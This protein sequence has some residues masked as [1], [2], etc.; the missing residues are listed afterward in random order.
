MT[1]R[2]DPVVRCNSTAGVEGAKKKA[3][4]RACSVIHVASEAHE[5]NQ[6]VAAPTGAPVSEA[7][8]ARIREERQAAGHTVRGL[9]ARIDVSPSLISQ[10]ERGRATPSVGTLWAIATEL[11]IPVGDLFDGAA[12][13]R[14]ARAASSPVQARETR[15]AIT[16]AGGVRWERLTP[17]PDHDVD[18]IYVVYPVGAESCPP[19]AL[20]RHGGKEYGYVISGTLGVQIGFDEHVVRPGDSICFDSQ[21]PHRLWAIGSEPAVAVWTVLNRHSDDRAAPLRK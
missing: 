19:D 15:K 12:T 3:A 2:N 20:S 1:L 6:V 9:A 4:G 21:R 13:A 11:D 17:T 18:F 7:L 14:T 5:I 16:L 8:G 10:I